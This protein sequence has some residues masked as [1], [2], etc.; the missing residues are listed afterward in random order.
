M[1]FADIATGGRDM[2]S[3]T[4]HAEP[5][6]HEDARRHEGSCHCGAVRFA[7]VV[8]AK[9]ASKCNCTICTKVSA[10]GAIVKPDAFTL[11]EGADSLSTYAWGHRVSTRFFCKHCGIHCFARGHLK[12]LG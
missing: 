5:V 7:V 9:K 1:L 3:E 2:Q 11:L 8:D 6:A 4:F 10:L 12:E